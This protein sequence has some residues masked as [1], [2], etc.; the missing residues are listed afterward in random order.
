MEIDRETL[1]KFLEAFVDATE[2][3]QRELTLYQLMFSAACTTQGLT[4]EEMQGVIERARHDSAVKIQTSTRVGF[5]ALRAKVP[6]IIDLLASD[7]NKALQFLKE[8]T[9]KGPPH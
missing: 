2:V 3:L 4:D 1:I 5:Q 7:Q 9:P 8:W 6:H